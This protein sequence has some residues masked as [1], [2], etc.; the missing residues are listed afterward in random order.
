[1]PLQENVQ[2]D[3]FKKIL[4]CAEFHLVTVGDTVGAPAVGA[5]AA[6]APTAGQVAITSLG[7]VEAL[8]RLI[9]AAS[10]CPETHENAVIRATNA[11]L[12]LCRG[13]SAARAKMLDTSALAHPTVH[14]T[15]ALEG[16]SAC[17]RTSNPY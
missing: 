9:A 13:S 6:V 12:A 7:A 16:A 15:L 3:D 2:F 10:S 14:V 4:S 11:L 17:F 8:L 1:M 5:I